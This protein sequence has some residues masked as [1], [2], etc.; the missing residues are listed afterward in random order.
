MKQTDS[1]FQRAVSKLLIE[2][3]DGP[4]DDEAYILNP[5]DLGLHRQLEGISSVRA[6][7]QAIPG[8]TFASN[9]GIGDSFYDATGDDNVYRRVHWQRIF[10]DI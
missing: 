6:S 8:S 9:C 3:F 5:G 7:Q 10:L 4:P 1:V 2:I